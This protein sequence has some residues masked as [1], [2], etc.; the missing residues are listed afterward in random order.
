MRQ[1]S[2]DEVAEVSAGL[3]DLEEGAIALLGIGVGLA[4]GGLGVAA[5]FAVGG[6]IALSGGQIATELY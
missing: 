5:Y 4:T 3:T 2:T 6:S 1:L